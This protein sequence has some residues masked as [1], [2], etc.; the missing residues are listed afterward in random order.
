ME[1]VTPLA[2]SRSPGDP[3][4]FSPAIGCRS[5]CI[6]A[7]AC[8]LVVSIRST[9]AGSISLVRSAA[10]TMA[11]SEVI[12]L[13]HGGFMTICHTA[14]CNSFRSCSLSISVGTGTEADDLQLHR[15]AWLSHETGILEPRS[16]SQPS[17]QRFPA[18]E[19]NVIG[20]SS[21]M[22]SGHVS[23]SASAW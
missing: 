16:R 1:A 11:A 8:Q 15:T 18:A 9:K 3:P 21:G 20:E 22:S 12:D 4:L 13:G 19:T 6:S 17:L 23:L 2:Q 7:I 5:P 10:E 14:S